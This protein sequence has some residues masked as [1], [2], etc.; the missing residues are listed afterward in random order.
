LLW[1]RQTK[2]EFIGF[3]EWPVCHRSQDSRMPRV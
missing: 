2:V 1:A 3:Q